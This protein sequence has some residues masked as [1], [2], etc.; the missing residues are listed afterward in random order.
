MFVIAFEANKILDLEAIEARE[1]D[2]IT[3][4]LLACI[5]ASTSHLDV[6]DSLP[7]YNSEFERM[8]LIILYCAGF[9]NNAH[10]TLLH[11]LSTNAYY[12]SNPT[13]CHLGQRGLYL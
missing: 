1:S 3:P 11:L 2:L 8:T 13:F 6:A 5:L 4:E 9:S 10:P 7:Q 12:C